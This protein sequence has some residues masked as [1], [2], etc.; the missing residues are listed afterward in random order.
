M[1]T[2]GLVVRVATHGAY[3]QKLPYSNDT[4]KSQPS[5]RYKFNQQ[6]KTIPLL[7]KLI[8]EPSAPIVPNESTEF[9]EYSL[10]MHAI[11][12]EM[13][14]LRFWQKKTVHRAHQHSKLYTKMTTDKIECEFFTCYS[15]ACQIP[16]IRWPATFILICRQ[17]MQ[18]LVFRMQISVVTQLA[19][20]NWII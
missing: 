13:Q 15:L 8:N 20:I 6:K 1:C 17:S 19:T 18:L 14:C 11:S 3:Q 2:V 12:D 10:E 9:T 4:L 5:R 7:S 16:S